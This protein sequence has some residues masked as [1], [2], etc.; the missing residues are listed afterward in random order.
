MNQLVQT[1]STT[2]EL[3]RVT[4]G[5]YKSE[6][7]DFLQVTLKARVKRVRLVKAG[8]GDKKLYLLIIH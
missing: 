1:V 3:R 6:I 4:A 8:G 5:S 7:P 2:I